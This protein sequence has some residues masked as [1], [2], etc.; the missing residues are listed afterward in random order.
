MWLMVFIVSHIS[1][2]WNSFIWCKASFLN[3]SN[4]YFTAE[5]YFQLYMYIYCRSPDPQWENSFVFFV[6]VTRLGVHLWRQSWLTATCAAYATC[7]NRLV[8]NW[9]FLFWNSI[10]VIRGSLQAAW[11]DP[12]S[13]W[14]AGISHVN[15]DLPIWPSLGDIHCSAK[16]EPISHKELYLSQIL[17]SLK[18]R[19][20]FKWTA[21]SLQQKMKTCLSDMQ[22]S[23]LKNVCLNVAAHMPNHCCGISGCY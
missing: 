11:S 2:C 9:K 13:C 23:L 8:P 14:T 18:Y 20:L 19:H 12:K 16:D 5:L 3:G 1:G 10:A 6:P 15:L 17:Q 22:L 21:N 4:I 7:T